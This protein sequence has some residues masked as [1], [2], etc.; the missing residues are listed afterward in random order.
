LFPEMERYSTSACPG[1]SGW[2]GDVSTMC[3]LAARAAVETPL[4]CLG[5][6]VERSRVL[7]LRLIFSGRNIAHNPVSYRY[8]ARTALLLISAVIEHDSEFFL[9]YL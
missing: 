8:S 9:N 4:S 1:S 7:S 6:T 3:H 5:D 2:T